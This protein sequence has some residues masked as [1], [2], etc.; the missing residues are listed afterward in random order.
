MCIMNADEIGDSYPG[1]DIKIDNIYNG[2]FP[3][4]E[5]TYCALIRLAITRHLFL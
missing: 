2:L 5:R 4:Q 1:E 3:N